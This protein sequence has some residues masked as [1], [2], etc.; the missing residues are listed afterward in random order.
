VSTAAATLTFIPAKERF[1]FI[2]VFNPCFF[3]ENR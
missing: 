1:E 2:P 3:F